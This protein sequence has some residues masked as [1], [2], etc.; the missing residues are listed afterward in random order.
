MEHTYLKQ[1]AQ[2]LNL[3]NADLAA[4]SNLSPPRLSNY[5]RGRVSLDYSKI[6]ELTDVI[7]DFEKL[8]TYFPVPIGAGDPKLLAIAVERFRAGLFDDFAKL[9]QSIDWQKPEGLALKFPKIFIEK[10]PRKT[11]TQS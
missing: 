11:K 4:L 6:K 1:R 8:Q 3:K 2:R 7:S 10:T 9:T 5:F